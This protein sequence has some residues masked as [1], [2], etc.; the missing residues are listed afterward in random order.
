MRACPFREGQRGSFGASVSDKFPSFN[1]SGIG[2]IAVVT[3][4]EL[5]VRAWNLNWGASLVHKHVLS[6]QGNVIATAV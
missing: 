4:A 6:A 3:D 5:S 2:L 1:L